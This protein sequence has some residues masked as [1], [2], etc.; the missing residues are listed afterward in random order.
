[1]RLSASPACLT[2]TA[3]LIAV[4]VFAADAESGKKKAEACVACHG[5]NG[6]STIGTFPILAGQTWR[7]LYLQLR[8]FKEERRKDPNM[9]PIAASLSK[10][11]MFD[12][13]EYFST[14]KPAPL[15]FK[16]DERRVA[17]GAKTSAD[18]LCTMCHLGQM[19]G[20]NEIPRLAGQQPEYV[21][22]QMKDFKSRTRTNDAGSMTSVSQTLSDEDIQNL[23][24]Y[25]ASLF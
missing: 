5:P 7:Y 20:Q 21:I 2:L 16:P 11:D 6:N 4:S 10:E 1:M 25:T 18:V 17:A 19:K 8:D 12:L 22:K 13:A 14:Q 24:H 23:A 9:S 3:G 15:A